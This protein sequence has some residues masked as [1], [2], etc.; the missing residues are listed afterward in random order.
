MRFKLATLLILAFT[1][2]IVVAI[3]RAQSTDPLAIST[4]QPG[5]T[6]TIGDSAVTV[7]PTITVSRPPADM[8][9]GEFRTRRHGK[10]ASVNSLRH[11]Q[12]ISSTVSPIHAARK[13]KPWY[14][15]ENLHYW[16]ARKVYRKAKDTLCLSS[17]VRHLAG[18]PGHWHWPSNTSAWLCIHKYE[19]SWSDPN[20]PYYGGL[21]MDW[22]FMSTYGPRLL[23]HKGTANYWKAIEQ[24]WVAETARRSGRGY[25]PWPNTARYCGLI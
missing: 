1:A 3:A 13:I 19:G 20:S 22:G 2:G 17:L 5:S 10:V 25:Y 18:G 24:V 9:L 15:L 14:R 12:C 16:Q 8:S 7:P 11:Q 21:Q 23:R 4:V 6:V